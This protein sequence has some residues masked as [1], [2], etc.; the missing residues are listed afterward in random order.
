MSDRD[1]NK[2]RLKAEA[3]VT[4]ATPSP[5]PPDSPTRLNRPLAWADKILAGIDGFIARWLPPEFNP[6]AHTGAAANY[7]L[8]VAVVSGVALLIWYSPSVQFAYSSV[9]GMAPRTLGG[10]MRAVHRYSSDLA[11]FFA[12]VH[13]G[14]VFVARKFAGARWLPWVTGVVLIA[15]VWFI[16]WTGYW[17]VWDQPAQVVAV[18]SMQFLDGLPIF[19]EPLGRLYVTDRLVPSLLFFVVFFLHMLLPLGIAVGLTVHLMRVSRAKLFPNRQTTIALSAGLALAALLVPAPLDEPARMAIKPAAL[20]VDA[21]YLTPLA[22]ALRFQHA[23]LWLAL[24]GAVGVAGAMPWVLGRRRAPATFQAF[25]TTERCNACTQCSRDCPFDAITMV[26]RTDGKRFPTQAFVDPAKC[27]GCG[28][29]GGS[30]DSAGIALQWFDTEREEVRIETETRAALAGGGAPWVALV[31]GDIDGGADL[32]AAARWRTRLPGYQ[33]HFVP[34][35]SWVRPTLIE[36]LSQN[37]A[38]GVLIVADA[39]AEAA[40]RHGGDWIAAR[41][42]GNRRPR[43]RS[44][45]NGSSVH[46]RLV[47][48]DPSRPAALRDEA[49]TFRSAGASGVALL[50]RRPAAIAIAGALLAVAVSAAVIAPSHLRVANP[51]SAAP[52]FVFSFKALGDRV[53]EAA[54]IDPVA[55]AAKPIHM[56]G[57]PT[58]KPHRAPV[59]VRLTIDG[60]TQQRTYQAKGISH[61]GPALDQWRQELRPGSHRV[62][63]EIRTG[64]QAAPVHWEGTIQAEKHRLN[65]VTFDPAVGFRLE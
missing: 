6:L 20:T 27:V 14:R 26:P 57:R 8:C 43:F 56:R 2:L 23:G 37:G 19:G 52:E 45:N 34:T 10:W 62:R 40:A 25:V 22:L 48:Y 53:E 46:W 30:C 9:A 36:R 51:A 16:G 17:L 49:A 12:L 55:E 28:V 65:V 54:V 1:L 24:F 64:Q 31:A 3:R 29:C 4:L 38:R 7:A 33:V 39:R 60:Q 5:V 63:V 15:L 13:A 59:T 61:D 41:L 18:S 50:P 47:S 11:M 21:W 35:A 58:A 44:E 42:T 32:F